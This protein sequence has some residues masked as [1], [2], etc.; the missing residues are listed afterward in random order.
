MRLIDCCGVVVGDDEGG[1]GEVLVAIRDKTLRGSDLG[2]FTHH[3]VTSVGEEA[4]L[5]FL[6]AIGA[7]AV[8]RESR[9]HAVRWEVV[10]VASGYI[11]SFGC[12]HEA[13]SGIS[14]RFARIA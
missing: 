12:V 14:I 6:N 9:L 11:T 5:A 4:F 3:N 2:V 1:V 13:E 10:G 8:D 7:N